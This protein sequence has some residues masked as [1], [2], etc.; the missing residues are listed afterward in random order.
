[1]W[2]DGS[3]F[4]FSNWAPGQPSNST[5]KK[6]LVTKNGT[7]TQTSCERSESDFYALC[8]YPKVVEVKSDTQLIF[9]AG[10][11]SRPALHLT[12]K[13]RSSG[14]IT[15]GLQLTWRVIKPN[16]SLEHNSERESCPLRSWRGPHFGVINESSPLYTAFGWCRNETNDIKMSWMRWRFGCLSNRLIPS[17]RCHSSHFCLIP[18]IPCRMMFVGIPSHS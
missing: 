4:S 16:E 12:W 7:W 5:D 6:C 17:F 10:N 13:S 18:V 2:S 8:D 9:T 14:N 1:M 11:I 3:E 15:G